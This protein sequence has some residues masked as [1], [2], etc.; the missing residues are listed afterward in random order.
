M[1]TVV[2]TIVLLSVMVCQ[3]ATSLTVDDD[4]VINEV[5]YDATGTDDHN[6][7]IELYN[8]GSTTVFLDGAVITDECGLIS[9]N[10]GVY[11]FP[12]VVGGTDYPVAGYDFV[13]IAVDA[14]DDG[15][16]PELSGA[17]WEFYAGGSDSDNPSVPN[18][19][20]VG[21]SY[22]IGLSNSGDGIVILTG[23]TLE[24]PY[25]C[26]TVVDGVNY[27]T[28]GGDA[29]TLSECI[30]DQAFDSGSGG[31]NSIGRC[32]DGRD[33]NVSSDGDFFELFLTPGYG[34]DCPT[35]I[36]VGPWGAVKSLMR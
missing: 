32:P 22:D 29:A 2:T 14:V 19:V 21:G 18:L 30:V 12:G 16:P 24:I 6:E 23:E 8:A 28:G 11:Q 26:S 3:P 27:E 36:G 31:G 15:V 25:D 17:D 5:Y 34:N 35:R 13:L 7:F 20:R 1:K 33:T 9:G 4:L 10:E